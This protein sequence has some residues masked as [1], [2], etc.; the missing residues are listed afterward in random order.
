MA[1]NFVPPPP[2][3]L[4]IHEY[5]GPPVPNREK[6]ASKI[7]AQVPL[8]ELPNVYLII[9]FSLTIKQD[10]YQKTIW[11]LN[12]VQE[13]LQKID[14]DKID[15]L[16]NITKRKWKPA[17][18]F[19]PKKPVRNSVLDINYLHTTE[20]A[21]S[22][23]DITIDQLCTALLDMDEEIIDQD[24]VDILQ[25]CLPKEYHISAVKEAYQT[26]PDERTTSKADIF[27]YAIAD[28]HLK[29]RL[30]VLKMKKTQPEEISEIKRAVI[31]IS[32][33]CDQLM[34]NKHLPKLFGLIL[35]I[36]NYMNGKTSHGFDISKLLTLKTV[37]AYNHMTLLDFIVRTCYENI[38][39]KP[40][41]YL[42]YDI[43][44][45]LL[46]PR[47]VFLLQV[48]D[49]INEQV[50]A[51]RTLEEVHEQPN[52]KYHET[53]EEFISNYGFVCNYLRVQV[54]ITKDKV[55]STLKIFGQHN[56]DIALFTLKEFA[57]AWNIAVRQERMKVALSDLITIEQYHDI[58][59]CT[60]L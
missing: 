54:D 26:I 1:T 29:N 53:V 47:N 2:G 16:F 46:L 13:M 24:L 3:G 31:Q 30:S 55:Q 23:L 51:Q 42:W 25:K 60:K 5:S 19:Q 8:G 15:D 52:D 22:S 44:A 17:L 21:L 50:R 11:K 59:I 39:L 56:D 27:V 38:E 36:S 10:L 45:L 32:R 33:L 14:T 41:L 57:N 4:Y 18:P 28:L 7:L 37:I 6:K 40:L 20:I 49:L 43:P 58:E 12:D 35:A 9:K 48:H 34:S